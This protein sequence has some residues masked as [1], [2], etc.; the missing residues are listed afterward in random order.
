M[1][2]SIH[3]LEAYE[4]KFLFSTRTKIE[5]LNLKI[6]IKHKIIREIHNSLSR[7]EVLRV[8]ELRVG[9]PAISLLS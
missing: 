8:M 2:L 3:Y 5:S 6:E 9:F 7:R 1:P 4:V